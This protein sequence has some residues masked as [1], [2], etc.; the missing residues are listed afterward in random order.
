MLQIR[1]DLPAG[2]LTLAA[3]DLHRHFQGPTLIHLPGQ[4]APA[5]FVSILLHGNEDVGLKAIQQVLARFAD[6]ALPREW[7]LFIGNVEAAK[8]GLRMLPGQEDFNRVWPGT[9]HPESAITR[10]MSQVVDYVRRAGVFVSLDLHNNTGTNP[11]Y[12][13]IETIDAKTIQLAS[14]FSRTM[15]Y[16]RVPLGVQTGALSK[17]CPAIT[18]ECGKV[19]DASGV[20]RA[21]ELVDACLHMRELPSHWPT[22]DDFHLL[23]SIA[24]VKVSPEWSIGFGDHEG[25]TDLTFPA[26]LD[27]WNFRPLPVGTV[28]GKRRP[29]SRATL[30]VANEQGQTITSSVIRILDDQ[31]ILQREVIPA[32]LTLDVQ[33]IR[34][35]CL[36]YFMEEYPLAFES[37]GHS[38]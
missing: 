9:T 21:G 26:E 28:L 16:F 1:N 18:C 10:C 14:L 29:G 17:L 22:R 7:I 13:C 35:D 8:H 19:G 12:S 25:T 2:F 3:A 34:D 20:D 32:M 37:S 4:R 6:R 33:V 38:S 30:V 27:H 23:H 31:I 15:V 24:T 36:G 5:V 11:L